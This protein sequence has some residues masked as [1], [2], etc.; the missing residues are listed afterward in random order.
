MVSSVAS[1]EG[2]LSG[3]GVVFL[4][5]CREDADWR[6]RFLIM[7]APEVRNRR[8]EVW[9]DEYVVVGQDWRRELGDAVQ[10]AALALLLVSPEFLA[11]RF[12]MNEELPALVGA[13]VRLVCAL[14]RD[15]LWQRE[16][17]LERVQWALDP[18][19]DGALASA[20]NPERLIVRACERLIESLPADAGARRGAT[21]EA[22]AMSR[23]A[24]GV[25]EVV[26]SGAQPGRL[27]GVPPPPRGYLRREEHERLRAA[28]LG[29]AHGAIGLAGGARDVGLHGQGGIGKTVLAAALARDEEVTHAFPDGIFWVTLGERA[30]LVAGQLDLLSRLGSPHGELRSATQGL[31]L[32]RRTLAAR[33]CLLVIDDVWSA[34]AA[35][36]F[37]ATGPRGRTLYTTRDPLILEELGAH[38]ER[39]DVL[40]PDAARLLLAGLAR[41][42]VDALPAEAERIIDATGG[43]ALALALVGAAIGLGGSSWREV[44][45][46]LEQGGDTFLQH[47]Y[48]NTFKAMQVGVWALDDDLADAYRSLAVYPEDTRVPIASVARFWRRLWDMS[49]TDTRA[50]LRALAA[51]K[52]VTA[53]EDTI[54]FHDLQRNFLL[55][56][57]PHLSVLHVDLLAAYR[58]LLPDT[59]APWRLLPWDEPYIWEQL[60]YHLRAVGDP[61][62]VADVASDLG[63]VALRT[64]RRGPYAA[65][66][67]L[68]RAARLLPDDR[69]IR[70]LLRLY[71]QYGHLFAGHRTVSELATTLASRSHDLPETV[72]AEGLQVLLPDRFLAPRWGLPTAPAALLRVLEGH[73]SPVYAIAF[74]PNGSRLASASS[75][76]TLRLWDTASG[77]TVEILKGHRGTVNAVTFSRDGSRLASASSDGTARLWDAV[78]GDALATMKGHTGAVTRVKFS[79]DGSH[80]ASASWDGTVRL[81]D[82]GDGR[83]RA[84]LLGHTGFLTALAF[85]P[86]GSQL[87]SASNDGTVRLWEPTTG[88]PIAALEGHAGAVNAVAFSPDGSR[89]ASAGTDRTVRLWDA[90]AG[91]PTAL[92]EGHTRTVKALAFSPDGSLLASASWDETVGLWNALEGHPAASLVGHTGFTTAV[93]FSPDGCQLASASNDGT[94][95]L[96][97]TADGRPIAVLEGHTGAVTALAFS[98]TG[99]QLTSAG[100]D[101]TIRLWSAAGSRSTAARPG[102][103]GKV[104][105]VASSPDGF[106]LA[107]AGN[108]RTVRLW[109]ARDGHLTLTLE[110]HTSGVNAVAFSPDGSRLA[111]GSSDQTLGLWD[112][113]AGDLLRILDGHTGWVN[114]VAF[115]PDGARLASGSSD[116]TVRLWR[117]A[118][119]G[120]VATLTGHAGT[121][122]GVAFSPDGSRLASVGNDRTLRLWDASTGHPL[123]TLEAHR[124]WVTAVAF[125]PDGSQ[126]ATSSRDRTVR[127]WEPADG[128][129]SGAFRGHTAPVSSVAFSPDGTLLAS[130]GRDG[131][132]RLWRLPDGAVISQL[133]LGGLLRAV[134]WGRQGIAVAAGAAVVLLDIARSTATKGL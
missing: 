60:L 71:E 74:S 134:S 91:A 93:A 103:I 25:A 108:D 126:L 98:P 79:P 133:R 53:V 72:D 51:R 99:S 33:R 121:V 49:P 50:H 101:G 13:E 15:C 55:L 82:A 100:N 92:L 132:V 128:R 54:A 85:S 16:P 77:H 115:S 130:A 131:T 48:A 61:H 64:F 41:V 73:T 107:S 81:W 105:A 18:R 112:A 114:A 109:D 19:R 9:A 122:T 29:T 27:D 35:A 58:A 116:G 94:V 28:L 57:T 52:L 78:R 20:S 111:S 22:V 67:D 88:R 69:G 106:R 3:A 102:H 10:R 2:P 24:M 80:L 46:Q 117:A 6:R 40:P 113:F 110:R 4:S 59:D 66:S 118:E 76:G 12:I 38:V 36:A 45:T 63:Y 127:L 42:P 123:V 14:V 62:E 84:A 119:E 34:A 120:L 8:L 30:D 56:Q 75:D 83:P 125:S 23:G 11:S 7:L 68:R 86:D 104:T 70:W 65:E 32:L 44:A 95:R 26:A 89:I 90:A 87:A 17:V 37:R 1:D 96:W 21:A 97:D 5:Y 129:R 47:S 31:G 43:V 124:D 39:V